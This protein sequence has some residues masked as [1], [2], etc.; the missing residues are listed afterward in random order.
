M[1][2][3]DRLLFGD[4]DKKEK[5]FAEN[6][7]KRTE[8]FS[9]IKEEINKLKSL[10]DALNHK[11]SLLLKEKEV[12]VETF[13]TITDAIIIINTCGEIEQFNKASTTFYPNIKIGKYYDYIVDFYKTSVEN[14]II[15]NTF[16]T[17]KPETKIETL[18]VDGKR[19]IYSITT[20]PII[21]HGEIKGIVYSSKD[22]TEVLDLEDRLDNVL[23]AS[24]SG[25]FDWY[26]LQTKA[27]ISDKWYDL[28][29][30]DKKEI[31]L[32]DRDL[33]L[34]LTHK[35]D[36][37]KIS[38][39][40]FALENLSKPKLNNFEV[41]FKC[42]DGLFRWFLVRGSIVEFDSSNPQSLR[43]CGTIIDVTDKKIQGELIRESEKRLQEKDDFMQQLTDTMPDMLWSKTLDGNYIFAN[44]ATRDNLLIPDKD[45]IELLGKNDIFFAYRQRDIGKKLGINEYHTFGELCADSDEVTLNN[46]KPMRFLEYGNV[47]GH[48]L[49]LDVAKAPLYNSTGDLI[50][51]VGC[52]RNITE[53]KRIKEELERKT[54]LLDSI[55]KICKTLAT[56]DNWDDV[57]N[58]SLRILGKTFNINRSY[59]AQNFEEDKI[60]RFSMIN[61]WATFESENTLDCVCY[62]NV[63]RWIE[64]FENKH[65]VCGLYEDFTEDEK[66]ILKDYNIKSACMVP[67]FIKNKLWGFIGLEDNESFKIWS[68][69]EESI[70]QTI[71]D[72]IGGFIFQRELFQVAKNRCE[73]TVDTIKEEV[74]K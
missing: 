72:I 7:E 50:G 4:M 10:T 71:A 51:T 36:K 11:D 30:Y 42:G 65:I 9:S 1:S 2:L 31:N 27:F 48:Y 40:V 8:E 29:K 21:N 58:E 23:E 49:A 37:E 44:K 28:L 60:L 3:L 63:P 13:D 55:A 20:S 56:E 38:A 35:K 52:G 57:I 62:D 41:R 69:E 22:I 6:V 26:P 67:I 73:E 39:I 34:E 25:Y 15:H 68:Y 74:L 54:I 14:S 43:V 24:E 45:P 53:E 70:L 66:E 32:A 17:Y 46:M 61:E 47:Q 33:L 5:A 18:R 12:W 64:Y 16:I 19:K 59:I